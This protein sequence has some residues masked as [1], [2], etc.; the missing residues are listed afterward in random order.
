MDAQTNQRSSLNLAKQESKT[1]Y[2]AAKSTSN[3]DTIMTAM[4]KAQE[5][6]G[7]SG[8]TFVIFT[9]DLQLYKVALEVKWAY[10]RRFEN[11]ILRLG[12]MHT[13]MSFIG[14]VGTLMADSGLAV[15]LGDVFGGVPK[16]LT[17]KKFPQ[18][19]RAMRIVA[20]ELLQQ[21]L[22]KL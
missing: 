7:Q 19:V 13:L 20:E 12:G 11:V 3:P 5:I 4:S 10:P 22:N 21:V 2:G 18:N 14:A 16:M 8:Q 1:S 9:C 6:T 17:G 15:I